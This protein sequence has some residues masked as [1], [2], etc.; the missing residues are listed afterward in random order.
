MKFCPFFC[1]SN[2]L[3]QPRRVQF[4]PRHFIGYATSICVSTWCGSLDHLSFSQYVWYATIKNY[5]TWKPAWGKRRLYLVSDHIPMPKLA[6]CFQQLFQTERVISEDVRVEE[7]KVEVKVQEEV[8]DRKRRWREQSE[9]RRENRQSHCIFLSTKCFSILLH[10]SWPSDQLADC[11]Q[12]MLDAVVNL[13]DRVR[14]FFIYHGYNVFESGHF[15]LCT[16]V[17]QNKSH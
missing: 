9:D 4:C 11:S 2:L 10:T 17:P 1:R 7:E 16:S 15:F 5:S 8:E 6:I 14:S 3:C 13:W 12:K